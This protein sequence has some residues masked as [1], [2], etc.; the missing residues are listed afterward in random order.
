MASTVIV[1]VV[2]HIYKL[3]FILRLHSDD[4]YN[5]LGANIRASSVISTQHFRRPHRI[6]ILRL[7]IPPNPDK[8]SHFVRGVR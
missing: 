6:W 2:L 7:E 1:F 3:L 8:L 5:V 4:I